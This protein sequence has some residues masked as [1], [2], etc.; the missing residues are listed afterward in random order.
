M[1]VGEIEVGALV[2]RGGL[3]D[4][5]IKADAKEVEGIKKQILEQAATQA[6]DGE[7]LELLGNTH[8]ATVS[9]SADI[10]VTEE[11]GDMLD[12]VD[13]QAGL[14]MFP[15]SVTKAGLE[16]TGDEVAAAELK[17]LDPKLF[18]RLFK[19]VKAEAVRLPDFKEIGK[20]LH[21]KAEKRRGVRDF[22]LQFVKKW[23]PKSVAFSQIEK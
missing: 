17:K 15:Y 8:R 7:A 4:A 19:S 21:D 14:K 10:E 9:F 2:D 20:A 22:L 1:A 18:K 5:Q 23:I 12:K 6:G 11:T 16:C 3:L 13:S